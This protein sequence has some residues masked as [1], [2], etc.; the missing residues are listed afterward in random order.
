MKMD[1]STLFQLNMVDVTRLI[2]Y[3][4]MN[5]LCCVLLLIYKIIMLKSQPPNANE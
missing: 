2:L 1:A 3:N 4:L 5:L